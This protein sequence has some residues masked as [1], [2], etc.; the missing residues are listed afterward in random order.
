MKN[1]K[2]QTEPCSLV[3]YRA[4]VKND[5]NSNSARTIFDNYKGKNKELKRS[6]L[7]EQG[8]ICCYCMQRIHHNNHTKIEHFHPVSQYPEQTLDYKNLFVACNG[9]THFNDA[10]S[11]KHRKI[12]HCDTSKGDCE[13]KQKIG[14][15]HCTLKINPIDGEKYITHYI[16]SGEIKY[17]NSVENDIEN[18][19]NLNNDI[20]QRNRKFALAAVIN[21]MSK[22][23]SWRKTE[24]NAIIKKYKAK[25]KE[26]KYKQYCQVIIYFLEKKL[27]QLP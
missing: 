18:I 12:R 27:A 7:K 6:L 17:R 4:T 15:K 2:K 5:L 22:K 21:K 10:S 24:I 8:F 9:V 14:E 11:D 26:G 20:L 1:I 25:D 23:V 3:K 13:G 16:P 19:L